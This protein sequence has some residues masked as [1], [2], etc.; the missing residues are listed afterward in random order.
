MIV[1]ARAVMGVV[2][3]QH[4]YLPTYTKIDRESE[5]LSL[6]YLWLVGDGRFIGPI[7]NM[8][9]RTVI[10]FVYLKTLGTLS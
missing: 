3:I 4:I 5:N 9:S 2:K 1:S 7:I 10:F 6:T 8:T